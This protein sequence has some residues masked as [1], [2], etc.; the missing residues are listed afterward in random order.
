MNKV[1]KDN[2]KL[3]EFHTT[4]DGTKFFRKGDAQNHAK[5]LKDKTVKTVE[6][7]SEES[8]KS[9]AKEKIAKKAEKTDQEGSETMTPMQAA[10]LRVDAIN[11]KTTIAEVEAALKGETAKSVLKAGQERI[12]AIKATEGLNEDKK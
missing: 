10:K 3:K 7:G 4:S 11:E 9:T 12:A 6:R 5:G 2:P 1:F 8:T